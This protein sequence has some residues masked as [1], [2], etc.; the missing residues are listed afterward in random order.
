MTIHYEAMILDD[1]D[2]L[3]YV[4]SGE[5]GTTSADAMTA[6]VDSPLGKQSRNHQRP[7]NPE[8]RSSQPPSACQADLPAASCAHLSFMRSL[9]RL[10][11]LEC[12]R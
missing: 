12:L 9:L 6:I 10:V 8:T 7:S 11:I 4:Y 3:P 2:Q 5:P 1:P